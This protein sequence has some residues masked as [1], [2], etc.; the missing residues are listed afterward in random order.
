MG[1]D[2]VE[3]LTDGS[4]PLE[5]ALANAYALLAS[6]AERAMRSARWVG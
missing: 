2:A 1:I 3:A 4:I 5:E 6:A